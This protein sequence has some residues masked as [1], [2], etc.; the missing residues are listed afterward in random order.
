MDIDNS[1]STLVLS[2]EFDRKPTRSDM[3]RESNPGGRVFEALLNDGFIDS[4]GKLTPK[5]D[6]KF[7][8]G[9][10]EYEKYTYELVCTK[11]N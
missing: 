8:V 3:E 7:R 5:S 1:I 4:K 11:N 10:N 2:I 6:Y 9:R